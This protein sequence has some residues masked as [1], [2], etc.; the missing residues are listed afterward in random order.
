MAIVKQGISDWPGSDGGVTSHSNSRLSASKRPW[1][2]DGGYLLLIIIK[3]LVAKVKVVFLRMCV[4][5][6]I[7]VSNLC[8]GNFS[9]MLYVA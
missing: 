6:W 3:C 5:I 8:P 4:W 2:A 9:W 1:G 7:C